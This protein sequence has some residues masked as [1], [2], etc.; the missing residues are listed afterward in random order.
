MCGLDIDSHMHALVQMK[1]ALV[2]GLYSPIVFKWNTNYTYV[3]D[4]RRILLEQAPI[5]KL[6]QNYRSSARA[7]FSSLDEQGGDGDGVFLDSYLRAIPEVANIEWFNLHFISNDSESHRP[8]TKLVESNFTRLLDELKPTT[9]SGDVYGQ[10]VELARIPKTT[11]TYFRMTRSRL[12]DEWMAT[13]LEKKSYEMVLDANRQEA[14]YANKYYT[15]KSAL[16][17]T[18]KTK[19]N[20]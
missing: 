1:P 19:F 17:K 18:L 6:V 12:V 14:N 8:A 9:L 11:S 15:L 20:N 4:V 16:E 5:A 13:V 7:S 3:D 2:E 10:L